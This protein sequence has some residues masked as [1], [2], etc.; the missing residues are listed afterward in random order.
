MSWDN[1]SRLVEAASAIDWAKDGEYEG[2]TGE[3][4]GKLMSDDMVRL[5]PR[6]GG[7]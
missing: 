7:D 1:V 4:G 6:E 5:F 2:R 3:A